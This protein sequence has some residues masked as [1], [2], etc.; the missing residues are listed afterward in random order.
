MPGSESPSDAKEESV[1]LSVN[2]DEWDVSE[3]DDDVW[4]EDDSV[5]SA[6]SD[7]DEDNKLED[8]ELSSDAAE[9]ESQRVSLVL[10]Q[11]DRSS[12]S[13]SSS[14]EPIPLLPNV[15]RLNPVIPRASETDS[16]SSENS[17][18]HEHTCIKCKE[19][20]IINALI[21]VDP[22]ELEYAVHDET[23]ANMELEY[24]GT[25]YTPT[26]LCVRLMRHEAHDWNTDARQLGANAV[27]CLRV[28]RRK[29]AR[30]DV[31]DHDW[32][33]H[34][35]EIMYPLSMA[36]I[37]CVRWCPRL[38]AIMTPI[39]HLLTTEFKS[40]LLCRNYGELLYS[41]S[42]FGA[43]RLCESLHSA[44]QF[45]T[46][47]FLA[48]PERAEMFS[49]HV[50]E[51]VVDLDALIMRTEIIRYVSGDFPHFVVKFWGNIADRVSNIDS[52][53]R[54]RRILWRAE[55]QAPVFN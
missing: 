41:T 40:E 23:E 45:H 22:D 44:L 11:Q 36:H 50:L 15:I 10:M 33:M 4:L 52:V 46:Q 31:P 42:V 53:K 1:D 32:M 47:L 12:G 3:D 28:L 9:S 35:D 20:R 39:I 25:I 55:N 16:E 24:E 17:S 54:I 29:G 27:K 51:Y 14:E 2:G 5:V 13:E 34:H 26:G 48:L 49:G 6:A 43:K 18:Y 37:G 8:N 21:D 7:E 38:K 19:R 30:L